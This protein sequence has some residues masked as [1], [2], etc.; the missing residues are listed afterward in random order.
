MPRVD[1]SLSDTTG[2]DGTYRIVMPTTGAYNL[3]ARSLRDGRRSLIRGVRVSD[4]PQSIPA[5][6]IRM[7]GS[8]IVRLPDSINSRGGYLYIAG[9]EVF[10]TISDDS[11][12]VVLDSI[13]AR[14]MPRLFLRP[15]G[16][17]AD[18][19]LIDSGRVRIEPGRMAPSG[20]YSAW[21]SAGVFHFNTPPLGANVT[22]KL[23]GVPVLI[24][25]DQMFINFSETA[26]Q[27]S[28][29]RFAKPD[30]TAFPYQIEMWDPLGGHAAV[31]LMIDTVFTNSELQHVF[32][33]W[34]NPAASA[35]SNS[36][37]VFD[38]VQGFVAAW[39][40]HGSGAAGL[41]DATAYGNDLHAANLAGDET[42][43]GVIG[44][45]MKLDAGR[46]QYLDAGRVSLGSSF[47]LTAW[48]APDSMG[49]ANR[50]IAARANDSLT[51]R[52]F[53]LR[54]DAKGLLD[55]VVNGT[56]LDFNAA[57]PRTG[58]SQIAA[59]CDGSALSLFVNGALQGAM[60]CRPITM[61]DTTG[62]LLGGDALDSAAGLGGMFDE[63]TLSKGAR[64]N[65]WIEF[66]FE[67]QKPGGR[68]IVPGRVPRAP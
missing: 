58:W 44:R 64:S 46:N 7:P 60:S 56:L 65:A 2:P 6:T 41:D 36:A 57:L 51:S 49:P 68:M 28:D 43:L 30:G 50:T 59:R 55:A 29:L 21:K 40:L 31:W 37:A 12:G 23:Y 53:A 26:A 52:A 45:G 17:P 47:T 63:V 16:L 48:I 39:H 1:V 27:G 38:T 22:Q 3:S 66:A 18:I 32:Y 33:Y 14:I 62:L 13:P 9:T 4:A 54:F 25:M 19:M 34:G 15:L 10:L 8:L 5:D 35:M 11:R 42:I 61:A 67:N 24:R 20:L